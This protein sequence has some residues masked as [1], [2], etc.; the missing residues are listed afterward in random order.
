MRSLADSFAGFG[1]GSS[2]I[3]HFLI[4]IFVLTAG[5]DTLI[6]P[7][8]FRVNQIVF[9][10]VILQLGGS[11]GPLA[12]LTLKCSWRYS[13]IGILGAVLGLLL[14][15][16]QDAIASDSVAQRTSDEDIGREVS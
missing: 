14:V 12:L 1:I 3:A 9:R 8:P 15:I 16:P 13:P 5:M 6:H 7:T 4:R 2:Y 10:R 11:G